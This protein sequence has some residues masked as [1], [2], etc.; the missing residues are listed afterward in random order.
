M[1]LFSTYR[2][3]SAPGISHGKVAT[4]GFLPCVRYPFRR[5]LRI[6]AKSA[7]YFTPKSDLTTL[8]PR[9]AGNAPVIGHFREK[10]TRIAGARN[11]VRN[12]SD[13]LRRRLTED[14]TALLIDGR[15]NISDLRA[16]SGASGPLH[17]HVQCTLQAVM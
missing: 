3:K 9:L 13:R 6:C 4:T 16:K 7:S 1:I 15:W 11:D 10:W 14:L 5:N 12:R 8:S 2:T 17:R